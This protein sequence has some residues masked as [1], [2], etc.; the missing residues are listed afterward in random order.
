MVIEE[1]R[2]NC[3]LEGRSLTEVHHHTTITFICYMALIFSFQKLKWNSHLEQPMS[4]MFRFHTVI[5]RVEFNSEIWK[6]KKK[7]KDFWKSNSKC[8]PYSFCRPVCFFFI[9]SNPHLF[10]CLGL[11]VEK[12]AL[13]RMLRVQKQW[14]R[15][16][17]MSK[18]EGQGPHTP[19]SVP[20]V[21]V[22]FVPLSVL[23]I[24]N[25]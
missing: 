12:T 7:K 13:L 2:R 6:I 20:S 11:Q 4:V 15:R 8:L 9:C 19:H 5:Y 17:K 23:G 22:K 16:R 21:S 24:S 18:L 25:V 3:D 1:G 10:C 14:Q